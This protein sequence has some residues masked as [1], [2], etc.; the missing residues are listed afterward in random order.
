[1]QAKIR[2]WMLLLVPPLAAVCTECISGLEVE[3][4]PCPCPG[5]YAC[6]PSL[7]ACL[8]SGA[9]CPE[10]Y[11]ASS[12]AEC[13]RDGDCPPNEICHAWRREDGTPAGP[14]RCRH[15]CTDKTVLCAPGEVCEP[16]PHDDQPLADMH[17]GWACVDQEPL[18]G[19]AE[20]RCSACGPA[21]GTF[22]DQEQREVLGCFLAVHPD[23]GAVCNLVTVETC[24][25]QGNVCVAVA[26]GARCREPETDGDICNDYPCAGCPG[27]GAGGLYCDNNAVT[28]CGSVEVTGEMCSLVGCEC[29]RACFHV[30]VEICDGSCS[31]DGGAHCL[32]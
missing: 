2:R 21:G 8:P 25:M 14:R 13:V 1:M 24:S 10:S 6:C 9:D 18:P 29:D 17:I 3:G 26:G 22:C 19:C 11:P 27:G 12:A 30:P 32:P 5:G 31:E 28:T 4:A 7:R 20:Q 23:C 16:A 15:D